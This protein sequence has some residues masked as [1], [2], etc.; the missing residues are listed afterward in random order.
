MREEAV[1]FGKRR[2]LAGIITHPSP[3]AGGENLPAIILLNAGILHRVGPNRLYVKIARDLATMGHVVLRFDLSGIG[4]SEVRG[5]NL[6]FEKS[7][8]SDTQEAMDFLGSARGTQLFILIGLC[9]G[10]EIAFRTAC[11]DARVIGVVLIESISFKT[12][13]Y[14]WNHYWMHYWRSLFSCHSW[15]RLLTGR[16]YAWSVIVRFLTSTLRQLFT[17]KGKI[18]PSANVPGDVVLLSDYGF[19]QVWPEAE[20]RQGLHLLNKRGVDLLFIYC[21]ENPAIENYRVEIEEDQIH[22][23]RSS[24]T[25][26]VEFIRYADHTFTLLSSQEHLLE[27]LHNYTQR[28]VHNCF[29]K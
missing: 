2:S 11:S 9:L 5:D 7:A 12:I 27:V 3:A 23:L 18:S 15:W 20:K 16:S 21:E 4:E 14:Y 25:V 13:Y 19:R 24:G 22:V 26:S 10:A 8:V 1:L 28:L 17:Q 6:P 29:S